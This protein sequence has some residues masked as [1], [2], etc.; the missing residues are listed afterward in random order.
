M[1]LEENI[2]KLEVI[3]V[4]IFIMNQKKNNKH[5]SKNKRHIEHSKKGLIYL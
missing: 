5:I 1:K 2:S 3:W 4:K